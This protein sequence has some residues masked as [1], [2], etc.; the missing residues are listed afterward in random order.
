MFVTT[1]HAVVHA[2][3]MA[4]HVKCNFITAVKVVTATVAV[5][6]ARAFS[7]TKFT[8]TPSK[9]IRRLN[10]GAAATTALFI[11]VN[12]GY[13]LCP[14]ST[15]RSFT[16]FCAFSNSACA[17]WFACAASFVHDVPSS[18]ALAASVCATFTSPSFPA[19][20]ESV[21]VT[22]A[23]LSPI[24]ASIGVSLSMPPALF[25]ACKNSNSAPFASTESFWVNASTSSPAAFAIFA[26]SLN[27]AVNTF[28]NAVAPFSTATWFWSITEA[29]PINCACDIPA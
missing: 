25:S 17:V 10:T 22:P 7:P 2:L 6:I 13:N 8:T 28:C 3:Q 24:S 12:T 1:V 11:P 29:R 9:L 20:V 23:P 19:S 5:T 26:G 15:R 18:K 27:S 14:S 21:C 16:F 4:C